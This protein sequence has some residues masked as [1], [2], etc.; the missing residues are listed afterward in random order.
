M[1]KGNLN[2]FESWGV[3]CL[4]L[5]FGWKCC[6]KNGPLAHLVWILVFDDQHDQV[7]LMYLQVFSF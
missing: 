7:K 4:V 5:K 1:Q 3:R 6:K 2:S